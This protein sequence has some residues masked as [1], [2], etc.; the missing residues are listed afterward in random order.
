[1]PHV[2][3]DVLSPCEHLPQEDAKRPDIGGETC[4]LPGVEH[5]GRHD[6]QWERGACGTHRGDHCFIAY[7]LHKLCPPDHAAAEAAV[8]ITWQ[9]TN[10]HMTVA[11]KKSKDRLRDPVL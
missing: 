2:P 4:V 7:A 8:A 3:V 11:A 5:L 9:S 10:P 1:M 6:G